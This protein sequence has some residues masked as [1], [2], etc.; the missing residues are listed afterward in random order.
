MT[1]II[2]IHVHL[3]RDTQQEKVVFP[4]QGWPDDWHWGSPETVI[5]HMDANGVSHVVTQN[6]INH[7]AMTQARLRRAR[8]QGTSDADIE[9]MKAD[10]AEDMKNRLRDMNDW[11]LA[12]HAKEPRIIVFA[13]I[14]PVLFTPDEAMTELERVI[15][16]GASGVKVHP[17]IYGHYPDH[18]IMMQVY[19]RIQAAGLGVLSDSSSRP[20]AD[21]NQYGLPF[22][23]RPVLKTFPH[24]KYI[25]AHLCD[26]SWDDQIDLSREFKDNLWFDMA[27]GFVDDHHPPSI[28]STLPVIQGVR[29]FRKVGV[30]RILYGS[31]APPAPDGMQ[32]A[33]QVMTMAFTDDEKEAI[34][35]GNAK[36]FLGLK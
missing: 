19:E 34:L 4:K 35:S 29:V 31:D 1:E 20:H 28:H 16:G 13:T 25:Q 21:G 22:G 26:D 36:R 11:S 2:D 24:L 33:Y 32:G 7:G 8:E 9:Q 3:C 15:A 12:A 23:W 27:G 5:P 14:D 30:E 6:V 18:P 17:N 10:L